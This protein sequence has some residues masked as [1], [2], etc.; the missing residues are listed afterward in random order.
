MQRGALAS[1]SAWSAGWTQRGLEEPNQRAFKAL[2]SP[3]PQDRQLGFECAVE[4]A[5][6]SGR[7]RR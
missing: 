7:R 6:W 5:V 3:G 4:P 2:S 1:S